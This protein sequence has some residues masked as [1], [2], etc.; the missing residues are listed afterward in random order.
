V[1]FGLAEPTAT[2]HV[3]VDEGNEENAVAVMA[4]D[5]RSL[6]LSVAA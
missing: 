4:D 6:A 3:V 1:P 2:A 5:A